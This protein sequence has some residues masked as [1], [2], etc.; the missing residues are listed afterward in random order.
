MCSSKK[1]KVHMNLSDKDNTP[2]T[3]SET[4]VEL[5]FWLIKHKGARELALEYGQ[6]LGKSIKDIDKEIIDRTLKSIDNTLLTEH[7]NN[8]EQSKNQHLLDSNW[9]TTNLNQRIDLVK[10][11]L[12]QL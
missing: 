1:N 6:K 7:G 4:E 2:N 9:L 5:T 10:T 11:R 3:K 12:N 8:V